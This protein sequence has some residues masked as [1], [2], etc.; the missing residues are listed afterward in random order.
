MSHR[1]WKISD[2]AVV[3]LVQDKMRDKK[4]VIA[5]GHHRY[6]TALNYRN[7]RRAAAGNPGRVSGCGARSLRP[8]HDDPGQHG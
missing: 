2:P 1:V 6:E 8:G 4:L 7:E 5:D 3:S